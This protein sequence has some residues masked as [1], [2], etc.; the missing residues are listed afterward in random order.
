MDVASLGVEAQPT[1]R[2]LVVGDRTNVLVDGG[3]ADANIIS[4]LLLGHVRL[5]TIERANRPDRLGTQ[6]VAHGG[7]NHRAQLAE[8]D[9]EHHPNLIV[10]LLDGL[11]FVGFVGVVLGDHGLNHREKKYKSISLFCGSS[12]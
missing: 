2:A 5:L 9:V 1:A 11:G 3:V 7:V 8:I 4:D 10:G 12:Y 6:H